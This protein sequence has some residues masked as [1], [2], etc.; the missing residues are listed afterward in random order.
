M[1][2]PVAVTG[3]LVAAIRAEE[4]LRGGRLFEDPFASK[5]ATSRSRARV[6]L[7][8]VTRHRNAL[9]APPAIARGDS[10]PRFQLFEHSVAV[11][12]HA[13]TD[14]AQLVGCARGGGLAS[15]RIARGRKMGSTS[16]MTKAPPLAPRDIYEAI[17]HRVIGQDQAVR[18]VAVALSKHLLGHAASNVLL[19]GGSGSGKTTILRAIEELLRSDPRLTSHATVVRMNANLLAEL[20]G[21]GEQSGAVLARL[22]HEARA[23]LGA[24]AT[25]ET[26]KHAVEHGLVFVD[27]VDKIPEAASW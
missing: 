4:H 20:A 25:P 1:L 16:D 18:E 24:A 11:G 13:R 10:R 5:L 22:A 26:I 27:E 6:G 9:R 15:T 17:Q 3:L 23:R 7:W 19:I 12:G 2:D 8:Q 14:F 21:R